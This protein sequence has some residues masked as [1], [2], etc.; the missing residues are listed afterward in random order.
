MYVRSAVGTAVDAGGTYAHQHQLM[1][2]HTEPWLHYNWQ[3]RASA[4]GRAVAV[5]LKKQLL[6][7]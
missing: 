3:R 7:K 1:N 4:T 2:V 6:K 5:P